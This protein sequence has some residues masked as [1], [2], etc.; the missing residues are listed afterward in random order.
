MPDTQLA[1]PKRVTYPPEV[2]RALDLPMLRNRNGEIA[3]FHP[4][5]LKF[6]DDGACRAYDPGMFDTDTNKGNTAMRT[7]VVLHGEDMP[8]SRAIEIAKRVCRLCPVLE[9]CR[10]YVAMYPQDEGIWAATIPEERR[11]A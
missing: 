4:D 10:A 5:E 11:A 8:K 1:G 7:R 3:A 9:E 6:M 2:Y